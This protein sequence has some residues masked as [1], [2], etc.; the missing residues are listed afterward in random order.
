[1]ISCAVSSASIAATGSEAPA[2]I[3]EP[4]TKPTKVVSIQLGEVGEEP[5]LE[6]EFPTLEVPADFGVRR[7]VPVGELDDDIEEID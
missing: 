1:M 3:E 6:E 7:A 5:E 4:E 2:V